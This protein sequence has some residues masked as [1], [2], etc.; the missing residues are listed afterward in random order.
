[1]NDEVVAPKAVVKRTPKVVAEGDD[2]APKAKRVAKTTATE[3]T[4][5]NFFFKDNKMSFIYAHYDTI[6]STGDSIHKVDVEFVAKM[7]K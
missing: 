3:N 4:T 6:M 2:I 5:P 7:V 1:M